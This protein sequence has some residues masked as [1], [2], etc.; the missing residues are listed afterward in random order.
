MNTTVEQTDSV[1]E[2]RKLLETHSIVAMR[3]DKPYKE[4]RLLIS[5][6]CAELEESRRCN[7]TQADSITEFQE[8]QKALIAALRSVPL[9]VEAAKGILNVHTW[10]GKK[11]YEAA[12]R[13]GIRELQAAVDG[14][15]DV[16]GMLLDQV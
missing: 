2:A 8:E 4:I 3:V 7:A 10:R 13:D 14:V 12:L 6:L 15:P 9:L 11:G 5:S 1:V 16:T